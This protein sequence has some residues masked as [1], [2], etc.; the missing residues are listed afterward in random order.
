MGDAKTNKHDIG[1]VHVLGGPPP[2]H[3]VG[4]QPC[5]SATSALQREHVRLIVC[6]AKCRGVRKRFVNFS[7]RHN[8]FVRIKCCRLANAT[9]ES[10][11]TDS[12]LNAIGPNQQPGTIASVYPVHPSIF[13]RRYSGLEMV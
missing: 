13:L 7:Y 8:L 5:G 1:T 9:K 12:A 3:N 2:E 6:G 10:L 4:A 11:T